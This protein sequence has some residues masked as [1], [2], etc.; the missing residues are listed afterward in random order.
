MT[1][2]WSGAGVG[3]GLLRGREFLVSWFLGFLMFVCFSFVFVSFLGFFI[4]WFHRVLVSVSWF[5]SVLVS[6][7]QSFLRS[8]FLGFKV[9]LVS[10]FQRLT[11]RL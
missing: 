3:V 5:Q 1:R 4:A 11:K 8:Q 9:S 6:W 10:K 7:F 2:G